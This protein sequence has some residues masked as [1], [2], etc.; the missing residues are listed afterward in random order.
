[1]QKK[2]VPV[3]CGIWQEY[4]TKSMLIVNQ[5]RGQWKGAASGTQVIVFK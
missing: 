2:P 3:Q 4:N 5:K 1:V